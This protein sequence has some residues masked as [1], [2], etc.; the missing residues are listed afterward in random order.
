M[1]TQTSFMKPRLALAALVV[2]LLPKE[3][4]NAHEAK[5]L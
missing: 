5:A 2:T 4:P 3:S 1:F